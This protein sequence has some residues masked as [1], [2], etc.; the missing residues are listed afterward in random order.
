MSICVSVPAWNFSAGSQECKGVRRGGATERESN[1]EQQV[2]QY[3]YQGWRCRFIRLT[4]RCYRYSIS[5]LRGS[6]DQTHAKVYAVPAGLEGGTPY[7]LL[8]FDNEAPG[9]SGLEIVRRAGRLKR[10]RHA[11]NAGIEKTRVEN[12]STSY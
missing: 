1:P 6:P 9:V 5:R 2:L 8:L 10:R 7:A 11:P 4:P 12:A 3:N